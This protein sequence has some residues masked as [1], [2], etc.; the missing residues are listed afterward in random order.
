[1]RRVY[2]QHLVTLTVDGRQIK[3]FAEGSTISLT[4]D[5]GEVEKT[6]GTDGAGLNRATRQGATIQFTIREDSDSREFLRSLN[7]R[8]DDAAGVSV[9]LRTGVDVIERLPDAYISQAGNLSTGDKRMGSIEYTLTSRE[10]YSDNLTREAF[11]R[12]G[13]SGMDYV[14][15]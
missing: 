8:Q 10:N 11:G 3:D 13:A 6:Q 15:A 9:I 1:M 5:G 7:L 14:G 12:D 4:Y 2:N